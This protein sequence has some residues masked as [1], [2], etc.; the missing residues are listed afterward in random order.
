[1]ALDERDLPTLLLPAPSDSTPD[2]ATLPPTT[3]LASVVVRLPDDCVVELAP[4]ADVEPVLRA[5]AT[6]GWGV[7]V[8][9]TAGAVRGV[10]TS[11]RLNA[12][13]EAVLRRN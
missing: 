7:V 5:M 13:A 11:E 4:G 2:I 9:T 12:V 6:T 10:V 3:R 8:V 1:M